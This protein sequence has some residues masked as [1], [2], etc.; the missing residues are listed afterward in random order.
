MVS[1]PEIDCRVPNH[2]MENKDGRHNEHAKHTH[3]AFARAVKSLSGA[4]GV[5]GRPFCGNNNYLLV[6]D[7]RDLK[8]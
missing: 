2:R 3:L 6:L 1:G 4:M 5:M 8:Y 7:N